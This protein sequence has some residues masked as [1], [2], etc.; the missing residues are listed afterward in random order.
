MLMLL[1]PDAEITTLVDDGN[2]VQ[3]I[4]F[5]TAEMKSMFMSYPEVVFI[6]ATYKLNDLRMPLYTLMAIGES[7]IICL[8]IVQSE[9]KSTITN[10]LVEF[11]KHNESFPLIHC[12][13]RYAIAQ[14][15][16]SLGMNEFKER[17]SILR[18]IKSMWD[19]EKKVVVMELDDTNEGIPI[20]KLKLCF[21]MY[22]L[23]QDS[24]STKQ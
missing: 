8:W 24:S 21:K 11:K 16:S 2:T 6:D 23:V 19:E 1:V 13:M 4:Y 7:E 22:V 10:L 20:C 9:D 14:Q 3:A 5:Q 12:V 18:T 15:L 17:L